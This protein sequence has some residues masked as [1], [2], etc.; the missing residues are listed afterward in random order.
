MWTCEKSRAT[1]L[2]GTILLFKGMYYECQTKARFS[3]QTPIWSKSRQTKPES[4]INGGQ[5]KQEPEQQMI[6]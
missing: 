6:G 5:C 2:K 4:E 3:K 1:L